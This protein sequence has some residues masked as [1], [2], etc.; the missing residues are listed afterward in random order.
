MILLTEIK[1]RL[2][3]DD[4]RHAITAAVL[5]IFTTQ[6][7]RLGEPARDAASLTRDEAGVLG[8]SET[9]DGLWPILPNFLADMYNWWVR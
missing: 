1:S 5:P 7:R 9:P 2:L 3:M 4:M 6:P 8:N